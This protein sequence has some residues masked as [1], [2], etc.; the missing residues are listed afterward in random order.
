MS[1]QTDV[2][3]TALDAVK[4]KISPTL[5]KIVDGAVPQANALVIETQEDYLAAFE[6]RKSFKSHKLMFVEGAN[7]GIK[8]LDQAHAEACNIR[9]QVTQKLD[10]ADRIVEKKRIE[11]KDKKDREAKEEADRKQAELKQQQDADALEHASQLTDAGEPEAAE[12]VIERAAATPAPAVY[13]PPAAPKSKGEVGRKKYHW[14][15]SDES[16]IPEHYFM[17]ILNTK[18]I[19][20][21]VDSLGLKANIPGIVVME[22][23]KESVRL[24]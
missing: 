10:E 3:I 5:Q 4:P 11:F 13:V 16:L 1:T 22:E 15:V 17:R 20:A 19:K 18:T 6:L 2:A 9:N 12:A 14:T 23:K 8:L 7:V 21:Q 24:G